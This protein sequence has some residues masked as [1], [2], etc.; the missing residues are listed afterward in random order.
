M[1]NAVKHLN[2]LDL[3]VDF[4]KFYHSYAVFLVCR[5]DREENSKFK[6]L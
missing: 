6:N 5:T 2:V 3:E 1:S 4:A